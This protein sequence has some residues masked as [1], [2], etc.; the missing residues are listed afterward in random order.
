MISKEHGILFYDGHICYQE[1]NEN[2]L[3]NHALNFQ[4]STFMISV[5]RKPWSCTGAVDCTMLLQKIFRSALYLHDIVCKNALAS[6]HDLGCA[7]SPILIPTICYAFR[8]P[9]A[10]PRR[11]LYCFRMATLFFQ[12][13]TAGVRVLIE[14]ILGKSARFI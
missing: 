12:G 5:T 6:F 8:S 14:R 11:Y 2:Y 13:Q 7:M 10:S 1:M 4:G 9:S 3:I